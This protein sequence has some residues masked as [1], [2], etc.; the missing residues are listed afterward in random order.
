[1]K[2]ILIDNTEVNSIQDLTKLLS[3]MDNAADYFAQFDDEADAL[4]LGQRLQLSEGIRDALAFMLKLEENIFSKSADIGVLKD[5]V[6]FDEAF[7][8]DVYAETNEVV[9]NMELAS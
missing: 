3:A 1:M 8:D 9:W 4:Y 6:F 2:D 7:D 5:G